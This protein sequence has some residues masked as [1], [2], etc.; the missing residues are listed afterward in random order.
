[1][2]DKLL[3]TCALAICLLIGCRNDDQKNAELIRSLNPSEKFVKD[4]QVG[5]REIEFLKNAEK[6]IGLDSLDSGFDSVYIRVWNGCAAGY[7][8]ADYWLMSLILDRDGW[9]AELSDLSIEDTSPDARGSLSRKVNYLQP[10]SGW[11]SFLSKLF[12][13]KLLTLP[14]FESLK[15]ADEKLDAVMDGCGITIEIATRKLYRLYDYETPE[16][17]VDKHS[18]VINVLQI[19]SLIEKEF[20]ITYRRSRLP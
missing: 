4:V 13:L 14:G 17:Y 20:G 16:A 5:P 12:K 2:T 11:N 8:K 6:D 7:L 3:L 10:K 18:E 15:T 1:M 9:K 19:L